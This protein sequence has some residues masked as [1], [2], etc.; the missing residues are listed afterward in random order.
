MSKKRQRPIFDPRRRASRK[1]TTL[2][3]DYPSG[4]RVPEHFHEQDQLIYASRGVMTI[5]TVQGYWVVPPLRAVWV[6]ARM[7]HSIDIAGRVSMRT[8]YF[9]PKV[10]R[11]MEAKCCVVNVSPLLRE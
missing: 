10:V 9:T 7:P 11:R 5:K 6:S 3:H 8:L 4:W 2:S 1:L